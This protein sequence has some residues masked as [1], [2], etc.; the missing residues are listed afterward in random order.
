MFAITYCFVRS[1][2]TRLTS[3]SSFANIWKIIKTFLKML[4]CSL[5]AT[6]YIYH[7][8]G[9]KKNDC[10]SVPDG[11]LSNSTRNSPCNCI[12]YCEK[13][14]G[15]FEWGSKRRKQEASTKVLWNSYKARRHECEACRISRPHPSSLRTFSV[16]S[17]FSIVVFSPRCFIVL[18]CRDLPVRKPPLGVVLNATATVRHA[19]RR[20]CS[21]SH[22]DSSALSQNVFSSHSPMKSAR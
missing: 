20:L 11:W 7:F 12:E 19:C 8:L 5:N 13:N 2:F 18:S 21:C 15:S 1:I 3:I 4:S 9:I 22:A 14:G 6:T 16:S 17:V 10:V